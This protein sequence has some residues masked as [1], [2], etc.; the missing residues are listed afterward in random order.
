MTANDFKYFQLHFYHVFN[1]VS[2]FHSFFLSI[3]GEFNATSKSRW[4]DDITTY[5]WSRIESLITSYG[6]DQILLN[7]NHLLRNSSWC[8]GLF[9]TDQPDLAIEFGVHTSLYPNGLHQIAN[10]KFN[11]AT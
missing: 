4:S 11:L 1:K 3:F 2:I 9:F 7:P 10:C 5:E 8:I 6:L